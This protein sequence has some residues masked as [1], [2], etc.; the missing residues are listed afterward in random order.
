MNKII[1][2][3]LTN[4]KINIFSKEGKQLLKNYVKSFLGGSNS[5]KTW[6]MGKFNDKM[7]Y[8][9][10]ITEN[11]ITMA[12]ETEESI[13]KETVIKLYTQFLKNLHNINQDYKE[14]NIKPNK[15]E[16]NKL[17]K[18]EVKKEVNRLKRII[19]TNPNDFRFIHL[20]YIFGVANPT[21]KEFK[22]YEKF[23][24]KLKGIVDDPIYTFTEAHFNKLLN[25]KTTINN[26]LDKTWN[27][28]TKKEKTFY[29][30]KLPNL[31][32]KDELEKI[33]S[34]HNKNKTTIEKLKRLIE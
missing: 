9:P 22:E 16:V 33:K 1:I 18:E 26:I 19:K 32:N 7:I 21:G 27:Y 15:K 17:N 11:I 8:S 31:D 13:R 29:P 24:T 23:L 30:K 28:Q 12:T 10:N 14:V 34:E 5:M 4:K 3:P 2:D 6:A 25:N 20:E